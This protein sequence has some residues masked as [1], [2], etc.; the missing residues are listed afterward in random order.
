MRLKHGKKS[1]KLLTYFRAA[2]GFRPPF[3][4]LLDGTA[5]QASLN[6]GISLTDVLSRML[7]DRVRLLVPRAVV[8]ELHALGRNFAAAAKVARR[9]KIVESDTAA[10][11]GKTA[12]ADALLALVADGNPQHYFVLTEDGELRARLNGNNAVPLLRFVRGGRLV[13]EAPGRMHE[14]AEA[15]TAHASSIGTS[16]VPALASKR[17]RPDGA[18]LSVEAAA[19]SKAEDAQ[20][21]MKRRRHKE[22]NPLSVKKKKK[23][24]PSG[25]GPS[26]SGIGG[27]SASDN[28]DGGIAK[29][30]ARRKRRRGGA[31]REETEIDD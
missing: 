14:P 24:L 2:H 18:A 22:P 12:A 8:A 4:V 13:L 11:A 5:I 17:A 26:G 6:H 7:C 29:Q 27:A 10:P 16:M 15:L 21:P 1:R 31:A 28:G 25:A 3:D 30:R 9:L 19:A 20:P 23:P